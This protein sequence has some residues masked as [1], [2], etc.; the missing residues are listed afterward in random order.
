MNTRVKSVYSSLFLTFAVS[1]SA[2]LPQPVLHYRS[3]AGVTTNAA[4]QVTGWQNLGTLG[5]SGDVAVE[6]TS[7]ITYSATGANGSPSVVFGGTTYLKTVGNV[8]LGISGSAGG[9]CWFVALKVTSALSGNRGLLGTTSDNA[10]FGA[11]YPT[12]SK[13]MFRCYVNASTTGQKYCDRDM[14]SGWYLLSLSGWGSNLRPYNGWYSAGVETPDSYACLNSWSAP[15]SVGNLG[16]SYLWCNPFVGEIAEIRCY[17]KALTSSERTAVQM[18]MGIYSGVKADVTSFKGIELFEADDRAYVNEPASLG[19]TPGVGPSETLVTSGTSGGLNVSFV[20]ALDS[21][22]ETATYL[23]HDGTTGRYR[24]WCL[25][26]DR[27][28]TSDTIDLPITLTLDAAAAADLPDE[29]SVLYRAST[30]GSWQ[31]LAKGR[32]DAGGEVTVWLDSWK[33]GYYRF[34]SGVTAAG[35]LVLHYRSDVGVTLGDGDKVTSWQNLGT[36]GAAGDV[37][38]EGDSDITYSASGAGG[39][40]SV[41]FGGTSCLKTAGDVNLGIKGSS[42]GGCWFVTLKAGAFSDNRGLLGTVKTD[43]DAVRFGAFHPTGDRAIFRSYVNGLALANTYRY[44]DRSIRTG[45]FL[46]SLSGWGQNLRPYNGWYSAAIET[47][48]GYA[49]QNSWSAPFYVGNMGNYAWC[50]PFLGEIAE[51]RCYDRALTSSERTAV[52]MEMG[53]Y[54]GVKADMTSYAGIELFE[55]DGRAYVHDGVAFG[56][57][58]GLGPTETPVASATSGELTV[59][60]VDELGVVEGTN[61]VAYLAH[62]G[63]TG[64]DRTWCL[65]ADNGPGGWVLGNAFTIQF[66]YHGGQI[67]GEAALYRKTSLDGHWRRIGDMSL[68]D[69]GQSLTCALEPGWQNGYYQIREKKGLSIIVR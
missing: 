36:L 21:T 44:S 8:N 47:P 65:S 6:G 38:V 14:R 53:I 63:L 57:M 61:T 69:D 22:V 64:L 15:F 66:A 31:T 24:T 16:S 23:A 32:K 11:F 1:A 34:A 51:I 45:W 67:G 18:E 42:G 39:S 5:M 58:H 9:G 17:A 43:G 55:A 50:N 48:D 33:N 29:V 10:R 60:Y 35:N 49:C 3:D 30:T 37:A 41:V 19:F 54:S 4:G 40:P 2:A 56:Y 25:A 28:T 62:N 68:S 59:G 52:Q 12:G 13:Q 20:N 46:L 26:M 27:K 7:D